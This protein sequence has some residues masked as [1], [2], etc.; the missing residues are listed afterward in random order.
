MK[1]YMV[2]EE[3]EATTK[4]IS[5][6]SYSTVNKYG[7]PNLGIYNTAYH[8]V[9]E[10][11]LLAAY[12]IERSLI[13]QLTHEN[14]NFTDSIKETT[15]IITDRVLKYRE[16]NLFLTE[17]SKKK[18]EELHLKCVKNLIH[19]QNNYNNILPQ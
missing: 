5:S 18:S 6:M 1:K 8:I 17:Y 19:F 10:S 16:K 9:R 4:I 3:L 11:D 2:S 14:Y 7:Y 13:Y 15:K 12:D